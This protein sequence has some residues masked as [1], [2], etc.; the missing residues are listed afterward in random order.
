M[1]DECELDPDARELADVLA[2]RMGMPFHRLGVQASRDFIASFPQPEGMCDA[3]EIRDVWIGE[4]DAPIALR[5]IRPTLQAGLPVLL[6]I[7]GGGWT[8]GSVEGSEPLCRHL[9]SLGEC[10]VVSVEYRLAPEFPFPAPLDDCVAAFRWIRSNIGTFGGDSERV[11]V[12]GDSAGGNLAVG[13]TRTL[14]NSRE[15]PP[16]CQILAYPALGWEPEVESREAFADGPILTSTDVEWFMSLYA[17]TGAHR[18]DELAFPS[19]SATFVNFP[20]TLI[21]LAAVDV[22]RDEGMAFAD[23]LVSDGVAA[24]ARVYPG[25]FHG[26]FTEVDFLARAKTAVTDATEFLR[27]VFART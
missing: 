9:A 12:G 25:V 26:F 16:S 4:E 27:A 19:R 8:F 21:I 10:I 24:Q 20:E 23:R 14:M 5:I 6:W 2:E 3:A 13:V 15:E 11:A 1:N 22:L 18:R 17:G 7:H